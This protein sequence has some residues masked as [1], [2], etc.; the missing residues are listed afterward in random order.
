MTLKIYL[1]GCQIFT[2]Y[3]E[4]IK[5]M[6]DTFKEAEARGQINQ[7]LSNQIHI[8]YL[9]QCHGLYLLLYDKFRNIYFGKE[10]HYISG[11]KIMCPFKY[12][13]LCI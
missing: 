9:S 7:L 5:S 6:P 4:I 11:T 13:L 12:Q 1:K 10:P 2:K 8:H 3:S